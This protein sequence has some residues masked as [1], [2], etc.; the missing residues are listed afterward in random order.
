MNEHQ[1]HVCIMVDVMKL[2][3]CENIVLDH[4][5]Y[6]KIPNQCS[7]KY[8]LIQKYKFW[9][10]FLWGVAVI[11]LAQIFVLLVKKNPN[12]GITTLECGN[13]VHLDVV[14]YIRFKEN[15]FNIYTEN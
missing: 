5:H 15:C 6:F 3:A 1:K 13:F 11:P 8:F 2:N 9:S 10:T 7:Q 14:G 12:Y 4:I